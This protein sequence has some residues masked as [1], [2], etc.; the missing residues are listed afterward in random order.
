M[1]LYHFCPGHS[2]AGIKKEGLTIGAMTSIINGKIKIVRGY[3]W[4]TVNP[5]FSQDW[6]THYTLPYNRTDYRI[7]VKIPKGNPCIWH[8]KEMCKNP[9]LKEAAETLNS[10]G[11]WESWYVYC[12]HVK[13]GW[14][15]EIVM[16]PVLAK[17]II[18]KNKL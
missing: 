8:W 10:F 2:L 6:N 18:E 9:L 17:K 11:D 5:S 16:N 4:L 15:R 12:G 3:Q 13:P 7:T 1:K 14:F